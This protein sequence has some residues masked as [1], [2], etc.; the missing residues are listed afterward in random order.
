MDALRLRP[1]IL[2][3]QF[4]FV[5][6]ELDT[7]HDT[8][9]VIQRRRNDI[10]IKIRKLRSLQIS[11]QHLPDLLTDER[12]E[13]KLVHYPASQNDDLRTRDKYDIAKR[14][15]NIKSGFREGSAF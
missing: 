3:F 8:L 10:V 6:S 1:V 14:L 11:V 2:T 12:E 9:I 4:L 5:Y 13:L 7:S 15:S